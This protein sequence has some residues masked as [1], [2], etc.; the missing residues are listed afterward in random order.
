[1]FEEK[2]VLGNLFDF[3]GNLLT[4]KQQEI[5]RYY[6]IDDLSLGEIAE[7]LNISRQAVYDTFK[8]SKKVLEGY[9]TKLGLLDKFNINN[10]NIDTALAILK[11]LKATITIN[12]SDKDYLVKIDKVMNLLVEILDIS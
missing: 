12:D 11:G 4:D 9:E 5:F 10:K 6:I 2:L 7:E 8:R 3:Y 1:M